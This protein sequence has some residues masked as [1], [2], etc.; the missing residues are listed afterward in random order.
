LDR[1]REEAGETQGPFGMGTAYGLD[2]AARV[3]WYHGRSTRILHWRNQ[4]L[5][6]LTRLDFSLL[7]PEIELLLFLN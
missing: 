7:H 6:R 5:I 1:G 4:I 2:E 3:S